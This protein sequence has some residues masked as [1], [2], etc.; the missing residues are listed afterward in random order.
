MMDLANDTDRARD[1]LFSLDPGCDR[2]A[3]VR[4]GMA[5]KEAGLSLAD[6]TDWSRGAANFQGEK[7]CTDVWRSFKA[8]GGVGPGTLFSL[9]KAEGWSDARPDTPQRP[10][11]RANGA[12]KA[13]PLPNARKPAERAKTDP[14]AVWA[15][16]TPATAEH[17]YIERKLGVAEGVRI[18][19]HLT[20]AGQDVFGWLA[21]PARTLAGELRSIQFIPPQGKKLNLP[22]ASIAGGCFLVAGPP[23]RNGSCY[24]VEGIGQAWSAHLATRS[25]AAVAFGAGNMAAIAK[26]LR[27]KYPEL[28]IVIVPDRGKE[29]QAAAIVQA[30]GAPAGWCELPAHYDRNADLNDLH[31]EEGLSAAAGILE[32]VKGPPEPEPW[33]PGDGDISTFLRMPPPPLAWFAHERL[34]AGRAHLLTGIGGSSKTRFLFHMG[35]AAVIG[36][37]PWGWEIDRAGRAALFLAEDT[38]EGVHRTLAAIAA[39]SPFTGEERRAIAERLRVYP[40]AGQNTRL[41]AA[42]PG[43]G[44]V[45]TANAEGLL[46]RCKAMPE[47]RFIGLDPALALT[48]GDEMNNAHQR[49]L[50]ELVDRLAIET[51]ACV[52]LVSHAAKNLQTAEE[53]GSH[54][55]RGGGAITDA[56]RGEFTMRTMTA[57]EARQF[58][59][60]DIEERKSYVQL[61]ATKGNEMPP[62]AYVPLWLKRANGG[63][64]E[65]AALEAPESESE[66]IMRRDTDALSVLRELNRS[67]KY[68]VADWK[69]ACL[70]RRIIKAGTPE[71]EKKAMQRIANVL[72]A[73]GLIERAAVRGCFQV[74]GGA[75]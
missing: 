60:T 35:I 51:G 2:T 38:K 54:T 15:R 42:A 1:A 21:V 29:A 33:P 53:I 50:G 58:G 73:H 70:E 11:S 40:L 3:W 13:D 49:R 46:R 48:E 59:V 17:G 26:A 27:E 32:A 41:L 61:V 62:S 64:L 69:A 5:A 72:M 71:S 67:G 66:A 19:P 24:L 55:S 30:I 16:C 37:T 74:A 36:R 6:F 28:R 44:L 9:A 45:E 34:L 75:F 20:I 56:V 57:A 65:L 52:V 10:R 12:G 47:L 31:Q 4:I 63:V 39:H 18:A 14:E 22:G 8:G 23:D 7:D 25:P 68:N 43:G